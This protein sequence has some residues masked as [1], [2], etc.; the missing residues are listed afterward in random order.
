MRNYGFGILVLAV[1]AVAIGV[2]RYQPS[3]A[4]A[5]NTLGAASN[6]TKNISGLVNSMPDGSDLTTHYQ[7]ARYI[8]DVTDANQH[9]RDD[10]DKVQRVESHL[11]RTYVTLMNS[12]NFLS[13]DE[14]HL[15]DGFVSKAQSWRKSI[16][17][18]GNKI[19]KSVE[20]FRTKSKS[21]NS[22]VAGYK[23][24]QAATQY[25]VTYKEFDLLRV[26]AQEKS[27]AI[28]ALVV[29]IRNTVGA[30][31]PTE[32]PPLFDESNMIS[33]ARVTEKSD[34]H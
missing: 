10:I 7:K 25:E 32:I 12:C 28:E 8:D 30:C 34:P 31:V 11:T 21:A 9:L 13:T 3:N 22:R 16:V 19:Q 4:A 20:I 14:V 29:N 27:K 26:D 1:F 6:V 18:I 5:S 15:L 24:G 17:D 23:L 33:A 2:T